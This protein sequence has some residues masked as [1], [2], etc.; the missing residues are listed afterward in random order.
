M[1]IFASL[2]LSTLLTF[3]LAPRAHAEEQMPSSGI[4]NKLMQM[5][6]DWEKAYQK[7]DH[8][9]LAGMVADD[10]CGMSAKGKMRSKADVLS[11]MEE[12]ATVT[13]AVNKNM[14]VHVY[15]PNLA[16]VYGISTKK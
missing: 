8:A 3:A 11:E 10:F 16:T 5:E 12:G 1:K 13:S 14:D 7:K 2:L 9:T 6:N 4:K 15:A